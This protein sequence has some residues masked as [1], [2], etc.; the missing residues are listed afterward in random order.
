MIQAYN[1]QNALI[2][3]RKNTKCDSENGISGS[4]IAS[5]EES[6]HVESTAPADT[7]QM[8]HNDQN[9][10]HEDFPGKLSPAR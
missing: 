9:V 5:A 10:F 6:H 8:N 2:E 1:R 3:T 7:G 4:S